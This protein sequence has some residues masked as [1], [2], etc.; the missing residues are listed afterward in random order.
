MEA[1]FYLRPYRP[2][3]LAQIA[4]LFYDT[5]HAVCAKDYSP[6][7]L[8]AWATGEVDGKAWNEAFLCHYTLVAE[9]EGKLLGFGDITLDGYLD[10][11]YVHKDFQGRGIAKALCDALEQA[12]P[13]PYT[14]HA[15]LTAR[16]FFEKRGYR[17]LRQQ[18]VERRGV[19]L[20]N[21]LMEK[22]K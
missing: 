22:R 8:D 11:L 21:F 5:V 6:I 19:M 17:V 15:S 4:Q 10:R 1:A 2:E 16:R 18:Q 13:G 9:G 14:T 12:V 20:T 7:Q 3:D